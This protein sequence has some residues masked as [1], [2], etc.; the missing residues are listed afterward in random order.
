LTESEGFL[1]V[2]A[3]ICHIRHKALNRSNSTESC[4]PSGKIHAE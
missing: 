4:H 1:Q 3:A 2:T